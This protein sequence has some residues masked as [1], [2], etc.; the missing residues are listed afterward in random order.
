MVGSIFRTRAGFH[1]RGGRRRPR[2]AAV[3]GLRHHL[4]LPSGR[5]GASKHQMSMNGRRDDFILADFE[6]C[7]RTASINR[8]HV[9]AMVE[10]VRAALAQ[11]PQFAD[12]AGGEAH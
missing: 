4:E 10:E 3:A 6:A 1:G 12:A 7:A 2:L 8:G 11:W 9:R 5:G